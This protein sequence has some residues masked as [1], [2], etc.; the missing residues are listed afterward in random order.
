MNRFHSS[1]AFTLHEIL[2]SAAIL[3][4]ICAALFSGAVSLHRSLTAAEQFAAAKSDQARLSDYLAMDLRRALKVE[5]GTDGTTI[6][7]ITIPDYYDP[8][9]SVP[10]A[11]T[12]HIVNSEVQY[13]DSSTPGE[14]VATVVY[15]KLG[16][17]IFR[18]EHDLPEREI[19]ANVD[20]FKITLRDLGKVVNTEITFQ[21]RFS[22]KATAEARTASTVYNTTLLRNTRKDLK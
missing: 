10:A 12:P 19:A 1:E 11:R 2:V 18:K 14:E 8:Q 21:P 4:L 16:S 15:R 9:S 6:A 5:S 13:G 20:D 22:T 7:T 3:S 17:S